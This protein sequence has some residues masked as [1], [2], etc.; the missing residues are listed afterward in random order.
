MA[1]GFTV[2]H[3]NYGDANYG[4]NLQLQKMDSI[5]EDLNTA[6]Q[7]IGTASGGKATP[8]WEEQQQTWNASYIEMKSQLGGHVTSSFNVAGLF[9]DGDDHG[10]R[11]MS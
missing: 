11:V 6:L 5:M 3:G 9:R 1:D 4:L 7:L 2:N 8:L 10:A